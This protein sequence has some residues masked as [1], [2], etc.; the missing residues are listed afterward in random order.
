MFNHANVGVLNGIV[1]DG[2]ISDGI[3]LHSTSCPTCDG[4]SLQKR[5]F[6]ENTRS[7]IFSNHF[8]WPK[9]ILLTAKM[10]NL[11]IISAMPLR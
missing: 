3:L 6:L 7:R 11:E 10:L 4:A 1:R 9:V 5:I 8:I 2:T